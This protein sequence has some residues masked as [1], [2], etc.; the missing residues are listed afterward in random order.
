[1]FTRF[2]GSVFTYALLPTTDMARKKQPTK[3]HDQQGDVKQRLLNAGLR[4]FAQY[5]YGGATVR[6]IC[7]EAESNIAAINY[8]FRDKDGYFDAVRDYARSL[9]VEQQG[10]LL[11]HQETTQPWDLLRLHINSLLSN[12]YDNR[13]FQAS[14]LLMR[15]FLDIDTKK[16]LKDTDSAL[17]QRERFQSQ[18]TQMMSNLLGPAAATEKNVLLLRYSYL[19]MSFFLIIQKHIEDHLSN[20]NGTVSLS[21]MVSQDDLRDFILSTIQRAVEKMQ[22]D[23]ASAASTAPLPC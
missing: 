14:W 5:G 19:S 23:A 8:Y 4:I 3:H 16:H 1:M 10:E 9:L 7:D 6:T 21:Q 2:F 17:K 12:C 18:I 20:E 22:K 11:S 15:E 13:L